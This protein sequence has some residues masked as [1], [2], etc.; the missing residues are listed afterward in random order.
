[1]SHELTETDS[2]FS[3][4]EMPWHKLGT[5]LT[6]YPTRA[7][8][9][10]IAHDWEPVAA[11][12]FRRVPSIDADGNLTSTYEEV[13]GYV[14]QE[15]SDNGDLIAATTSTLVNVSNASMYDVAEAMETGAPAGDV[16]YE[17]GGSLNGGKRVWLMM[18]LREPLVI[19]G[20]PNGA[21][22]PFF[23]LQNNHDGKG[24]F[25]GSATTVRIVCS[26]T[27]RAADLDATAR[28]TEFTFKHTLNVG[29]RVEEA[30]Q[31]L[32][33]WRESV[34]DYRLLAEHMLTLKV[35]Q[36]ETHE[37]LERFIPA[38]LSTMTS[39]RVKRNIEEARG[40][41]MGVYNSATNEGITGT[42]WGLIQASSEWSEHVRR[43]NSEET[44]FKRA[45]LESNQVIAD[46][47]RLAL[48]VAR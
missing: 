21:T 40:E 18:R 4:R 31:A 46:A 26:N 22:I 19:K 43:A 41:W 15:R 11:P 37:F 16:M 10:K 47:K 33:G 48:A 13:E 23:A 35:N 28:G 29:D 6:E 38:P 14:A 45:M 12:L 27:V 3:V 44:R 17:T 2:M 8:A 20:D 9:Q 39:D 30:R 5:V 25:R 32:A 36:R 24:S 34:E 42:A 1:M 7:E